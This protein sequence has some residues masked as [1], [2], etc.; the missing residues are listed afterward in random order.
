MMEPEFVPADLE[1]LNQARAILNEHGFDTEVLSMCIQVLKR[2]FP[3]TVEDW[4]EAVAA[5]AVYESLWNGR[6][7]QPCQ[8]KR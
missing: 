8:T 7:E 5:G 4:R 3:Q 1:I 6:K 2:K